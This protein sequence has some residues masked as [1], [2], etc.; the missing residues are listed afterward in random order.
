MRVPDFATDAEK[1]AV[2]DQMA[3]LR[4]A[5]DEGASFAD[6][7]RANSQSP[8]A[9][10]GGDIGEFDKASLSPQI[11]AALE[12]LAP[13]QTTPVLDTDQGFQLFY[14]EAINR[15]EGKPLE[16]VREEIRQKLFNEVVDKKFLSWLD[17]LRSRSHIKII[18]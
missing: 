3:A 12:G 13:G 15:T 10:D 4:S 14:L 17:D 2:H 1:Q 8:A 18:N 11:Q 5:I 6:L 7:A 9:A 16:S